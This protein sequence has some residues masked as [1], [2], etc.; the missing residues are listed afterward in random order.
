MSTAVVLLDIGKAFDFTWRPGLLYKVSKLHFSASL[1]KLIRSFLSN[2]KFRVMVQGEMTT[3]RDIQAGMPQGSVLAPLLYS[4]YVNNTPQTPRV[5]LILLADDICIYTTDRKEGY[6]FRK[7]QRDLNSMESRR[8]RWNITINTDKI[9]VIY[10]SHR[11]RMVEAHLTLKGRNIPF[12][13]NVKYLGVIFYRKIT[14]KMHRGR[15]AA[16]NF[17]T[18][19]RICLPF[20]SERLSS[21]KKIPV[22]TS[23]SP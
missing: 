4:L 2:R 14:W 18:F 19:I 3:P 20:E 17:R 12:V 23:I 13:R 15:I 7:L 1:I 10:F 9:Q 22:K 5:Y 8:K 16:K 6:V 11:C 21:N